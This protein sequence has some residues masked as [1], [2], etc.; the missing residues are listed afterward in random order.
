M[1]GANIF[2]SV[3]TQSFKMNKEEIG[4]YLAVISLNINVNSPGN[5]QPE[6]WGD[7]LVCKVA[8]E[9]ARVP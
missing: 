4:T 8:A 1:K 2:T 9:P 6:G 5:M 7:S 3:N